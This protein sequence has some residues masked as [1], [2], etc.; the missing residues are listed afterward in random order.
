MDHDAPPTARRRRR[1]CPTATSLSSRHGA[2]LYGSM[3]KDAQG[4]FYVVGMMNSKP[5]ILQVTAR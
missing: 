5:V 2:V 3:T 1:R 4:R